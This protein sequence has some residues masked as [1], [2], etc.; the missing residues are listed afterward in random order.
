MANSYS[1]WTDQDRETFQL[2]VEKWGI[3]AQADMAIEECAEL[4]VELQHE[5]RGRSCHADVIDELA[6]IRIM[7]GQLAEFYGREHVENRVSEK[8]DR[9]R[10]RIAE[11]DA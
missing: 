5:K 9:L 10:E 11:S 8:M 7:Y 1:L 6:D 2:A 4:I 3:D